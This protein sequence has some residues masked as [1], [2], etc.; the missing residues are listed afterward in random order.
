MFVFEY[1]FTGV[2][3]ILIACIVINILVLDILYNFIVSRKCKKKILFISFIASL[4]VFGVGCGLC[5]NSIT[6]F[7]IK[8]EEIIKEEKTIAMKNDLIIDD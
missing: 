6:S 3:L 1:W 4:L 5:V 7:D 8:E 2:L